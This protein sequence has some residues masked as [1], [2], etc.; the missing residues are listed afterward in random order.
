[1]RT[2]DG[3]LIGLMLLMLVAGNNGPVVL[4]GSVGSG[5][6]LGW[7]VGPVVIRRGWS[8]EESGRVLRLRHAASRR[9]MS[10][11]PPRWPSRGNRRGRAAES[12]LGWPGA[13]AFGWDPENSTRPASGSYERSVSPTRALLGWPGKNPQMVFAAR[14]FTKGVYGYGVVK[15]EGGSFSTHWWR[16]GGSCSPV[17]RGLG[18][19]PCRATDD[20][21]DDDDAAADD[22][23]DSER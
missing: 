5:S 15:G 3:S 10:G 2:D 6:G 11:R 8:R 18:S 19:S 17:I 16:N 12:W 21:G 23:D 14:N 13:A 20:D 9:S 4:V 1:M 7:R 22:G